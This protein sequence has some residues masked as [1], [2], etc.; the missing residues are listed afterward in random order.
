MWK[1]RRSVAGEILAGIAVAVEL[2]ARRLV[3]GEIL[4]GIAVAAGLQLE[5]TLVKREIVAT[6]E[7]VVVTVWLTAWKIVQLEEAVAVG[8]LGEDMVVSPDQA[9]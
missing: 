5:V 8:T 6:A 9:S 4:A 3:A 1:V 2:Q 7:R